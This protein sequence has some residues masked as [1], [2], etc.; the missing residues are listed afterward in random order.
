LVLLVV[1]W[2]L[3]YKLSLRDLAEMFLTRGVVVTHGAVREWEERFAPLLT[4]QLRPKR[5]GQTGASW[6]VDETYIK[7][8]GA[9]FYLYRAIDRDGNLVDVMLSETRDMGATQAFF[10]QAVATTGQPPERVITDGHTA[11][12]RAV[13]EVLGEALQHRT[14]RHLNN[15]IEQDHRSIKQ[16]Y[17]PMRGFKTVGSA[18]RFCS[19]HE[20]QRQHLK[21]A[22]DDRGTGE[23]DGAADEVSRA[24]GG[25]T[26]RG[27]SRLTAGR[28]AVCGRRCRGA[29]PCTES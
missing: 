18:T 25:A 11:Y 27:G 9:R 10:Q 26:G 13:R 28:E 5:C 1:L 20:E 8:N 24:M 19:A 4:E 12:P 23:P 2:R 7:V 3:R 21:D 15:R 29:W 17:Y 22:A 14:S 16:R 6:Y